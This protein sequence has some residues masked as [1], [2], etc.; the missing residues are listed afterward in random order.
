MN[1]FVFSYF[2]FLLTLEILQ[3]KLW[4][5]NIFVELLT[6]YA[7]TN[8]KLYDE[9]SHLLDFREITKQKEWQQLVC[10]LAFIITLN[11]LVY[12]LGGFEKFQVYLNRMPQEKTEK[13]SI[14]VHSWLVKSS[15]TEKHQN[16][17]S[18]SE[19]TPSTE[20]GNCEML[21]KALGKT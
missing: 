8:S 13:Q 11:V 16:S 9:D 21:L 20:G 1:T 5:K 17:R 15:L 14:E 6:I 4:K 12:R 19:P 2:F 18:T 10:W 7:H 3:I